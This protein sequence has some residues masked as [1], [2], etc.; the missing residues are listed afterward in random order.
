[1]S[2]TVIHPDTHYQGALGGARIPERPDGEVGCRCASTDAK[3]ERTGDLRIID[4]SGEDYLDPSR[5]FVAAE[6]PLS[7]RR[8]VLQAT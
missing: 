6:F 2:I 5:R 7:K 4:E 1:M 3:A 8:A